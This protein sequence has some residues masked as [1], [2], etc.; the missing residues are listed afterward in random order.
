MMDY[1]ILF[2]LMSGLALLLN[3]TI[4]HVQF[5]MFNVSIFYVLTQLVS[6]ID[7]T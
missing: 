2:S 1:Y 3:V 7:S 6:L 4:R 5:V